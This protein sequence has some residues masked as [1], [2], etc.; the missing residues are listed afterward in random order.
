MEHWLSEARAYGVQS[1]MSACGGSVPGRSATEITPRPCQLQ[2]E[3]TQSYSTAGGAYLRN[4]AVFESHRSYPSSIRVGAATLRRQAAEPRG[5]RERSWKGPSR[6]GQSP[7][8]SALCFFQPSGDA[9]IRRCG[10]DRHRWPANATEGRS[11]SRRASHRPLM[12]M[13]TVQVTLHG[14]ASD[15]ASSSQSRWQLPGTATRQYMRCLILPSE[16]Q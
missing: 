6:C 14:R 9:K 10:P 2:L 11:F 12:G 13:N 3:P 8:P 4:R 1:Y 15:A 16:L 7:T 5:R